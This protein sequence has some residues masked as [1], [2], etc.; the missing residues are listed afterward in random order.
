MEIHVLVRKEKK[1]SFIQTK[2][3][4]LLMIMP[5]WLPLANHGEKLL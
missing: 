5:I 3:E 4:H 1:I 2:K